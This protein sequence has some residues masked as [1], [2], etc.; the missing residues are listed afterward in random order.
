MGIFGLE[1]A[2]SF[3]QSHDL[4]YV[5]DNSNRR[6]PVIEKARAMLGYDPQVLVE[7]GIRRYLNYLKYERDRA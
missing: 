6:C 4:N 5:T 1:L 7:E 2:V 3:E